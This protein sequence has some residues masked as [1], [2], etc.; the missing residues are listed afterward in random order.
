MKKLAAFVLL[1][2]LS[3]GTT[4]PA[5]AKTQKTRKTQKTQNKYQGIDKAS[6]KAQK[7]EQKA[8]DK[9]T[10]KQQKAQNKLLNKGGKKNKYR[11]LSR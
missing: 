3:A 4:L 5:F 7:R 6:R 2:I 8:M 10:R 9:Y 11:P 1:A